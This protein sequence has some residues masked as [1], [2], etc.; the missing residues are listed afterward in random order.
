LV[1]GLVK[2]STPLTLLFDG[3][4]LFCTRSAV[5]VRRV[6]GDKR[7]TLRDFQQQGA[8][9][10]YPFLRRDALM[11]KMHVVMP[12]GRVFAG[13]E[14]FARIV[15]QSRIIGWLGWLYYVPGVRQMADVAYTLVAKHRYRVFGRTEECG[16]GAC[17]AHGPDPIDR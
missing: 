10:A 9:D 1:K 3:A 13:A 2:T 6:F 14:G 15:M 7:V 12:D 16:D 8:L 11:K 5:A 4:C 17:K